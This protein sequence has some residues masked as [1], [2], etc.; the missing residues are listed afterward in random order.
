MRRRCHTARWTV[1]VPVEMGA[2]RAAQARIRLRRGEGTGAS[3]LAADP[4]VT[5]PVLRS[6]VDRSTSVASAKDDRPAARVTRELAKVYEGV[7]AGTGG[8]E[9]HGKSERDG[10][11]RAVVSVRVGMVAS[12]GAH[13]AEA[14][15]TTNVA[16]QVASLA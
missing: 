12:E 8:V 14:K 5:F 7:V 15:L 13:R 4:L 16:A 10:Y 3:Q 9:V 6:S 1:W 2:H 11:G